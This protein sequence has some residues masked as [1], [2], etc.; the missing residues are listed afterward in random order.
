M[1]WLS[2]KKLNAF[3]RLTDR[4]TGY[5]FI[6]DCTDTSLLE[7]AYIGSAKE[8]I[9]TTGDDNVNLFLAHLAREV[10]GVPNIYVCLDDPSLEILLRGMNINAIFPFE[11]S[12][13]C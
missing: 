11:L 1:F 7:D 4:F 5:K 10:Y 12:L 6:G 13:R 8:I 3:D 2:T 9:I